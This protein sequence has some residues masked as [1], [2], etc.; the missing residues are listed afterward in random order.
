[1]VTGQRSGRR[2][3]R[4]FWITSRRI[5]IGIACFCD[6]GC[7]CAVGH[8]G[9]AVHDLDEQVEPDVVLGLRG[10][11]E[12]EVF[13]PGELVPVDLRVFQT[14]PQSQIRNRIITTRLPQR[15]QM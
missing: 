14:F 6:S 13:L 7:N 1:M 4:I 8:V 10:G 12:P 9:F 15:R 2:D 3:S 11:E 5:I